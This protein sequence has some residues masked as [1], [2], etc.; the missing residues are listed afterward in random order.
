[1]IRRL[2]NW[3]L[4][5]A[6]HPQ[7]VYIMAFIAFIEASVFMIPPYPLQIAISMQ[8]TRRSLW[9]AAINTA[10]SVMGGFVGYLIG[11]L[12]WEASKGFFFNPI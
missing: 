3:A 1:M 11:F 12:F 7:A 5:F 8:N 9:L 2:Y 4:Q 10:S 6:G